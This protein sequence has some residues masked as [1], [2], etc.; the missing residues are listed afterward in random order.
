[1][2][3]LEFSTVVQ[4]QKD[5]DR[6]SRAS[7]KRA[8]Y[9]TARA[10]GDAYDGLRGDGPWAAGWWIAARGGFRNAGHVV[11]A[12]PASARDINAKY[13]CTIRLTGG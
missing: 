8:I 5:S 1:M 9:Y 4:Q 3:A 12:T 6:R 13:V 2:R 10:V 7:R 11:T